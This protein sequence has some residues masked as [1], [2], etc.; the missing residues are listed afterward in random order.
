[1]IINANNTAVMALVNAESL[2][3][4]LQ[5]FPQQVGEANNSILALQERA[6]KDSLA[7]GVAESQAMAASNEADSLEDR[8]GIITRLLNNL[9]ELV[10]NATLVSE[11]EFTRLSSLLNELEVTIMNIESDLNDITNDINNLEKQSSILEGKYVDLQRHRD[12]LEDIRSNIE[13]LDCEPQF[14]IS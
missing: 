7:I 1:M 11:S 8:V 4:S 10:T 13:E 3:N 2:T 5:D 9:E 14:I 6:E 12:L